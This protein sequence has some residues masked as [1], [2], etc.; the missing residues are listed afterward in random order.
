MY[1]LS[2]KTTNWLKA[3]NFRAVRS[4]LLVD[5]M[6][7]KSI[8]NIEKKAT[9]NLNS[10]INSI[11]MI[12]QLSYLF[13]II[14]AIIRLIFKCSSFNVISNRELFFKTSDLENLKID[15]R[16]TYTVHINESFYLNSVSVKINCNLITLVF[17]IFCQSSN[18]YWFFCCTIPL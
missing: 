7:R 16:K 4:F 15:S 5:Y 13:E 2:K 1:F 9:K 8:K 10:A 3:L 14:A 6:S 17:S 11:I 18:L 12:S